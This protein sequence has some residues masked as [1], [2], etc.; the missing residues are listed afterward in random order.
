MSVAFV[1]SGGA[2]LGAVQVGML[3]AL[4]EAGVDPDLIVG[5]SVGAVNGGFL[6]GR[7]GVDGA[8]ELEQIWMGIRRS[9]V[10]PAR[11]LIG[12]LGFAGRRDHLVPNRALAALIRRNL[13]FQR[14]EQAP[15]PLSVVAT[16]IQTGKEL[17]LSHGPA[18]EA[19]LA[20]SAIPGIFPPVRIEG[21]TL[22]DGGVANNTPISH[23][24]D[25]GADTLYVLPAGQACELREPPS[26]ALAAILQS[27]TILFGQRLALDIERF[28]TKVRLKVVPPPCPLDVSPAD[29]GHTAELMERSYEQARHWLLQE[30]PETGQAVLA[31]PHAH[32]RG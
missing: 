20:S 14:L 10:F 18:L 8:R 31:F 1:L 27:L 3:R 7:P 32:H 19:L 26:S 16:D 11:P 28:E 2:S 5:T 24:V 29:F 30:P 4:A 15:T 17:L 9:D 23:A 21:R 25:L 13:A 22:V 6:A 12:F